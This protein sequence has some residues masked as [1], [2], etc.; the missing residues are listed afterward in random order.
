MRIDRLGRKR[1]LRD[2]ISDIIT[3]AIPSDAKVSAEEANESFCDSGDFDTML[4]KVMATISLHFE[5]AKALLLE[6]GK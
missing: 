6:E 1:S 2:D 4:D 5:A 3:D